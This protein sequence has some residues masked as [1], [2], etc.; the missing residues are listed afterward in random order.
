MY[1]MQSIAKKYFFLAALSILLMGDI[2][3]KAV[4]NPPQ[5][6]GEK[7]QKSQLAPFEYSF[8]EREDPFFPFIS[9]TGINDIR[10]PHLPPSDY[11]PDA[12][13]FE[14]GQLNLVAI[15][16]TPMGLKGLA[17]DSTKTGHILNEGMLIGRYGRISK[18]GVGSVL[19]IENIPTRTG[20]IITKEVVMRLNKEGDK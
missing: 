8:D 17:E 20:R 6:E 14:P 11:P 16:S 19:V 1:L 12:L 4:D 3:A 13:R 18:I 7:K 9:S 15:M 10:P 2:S 5:V